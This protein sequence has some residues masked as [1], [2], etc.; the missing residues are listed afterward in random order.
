MLRGGRS[1]A[2]CFALP[3]PPSCS[4][5]SHWRRYA[6][7]NPMPHTARP[8]LIAFVVTTVIAASQAT[9]QDHSM[10]DHPAAISAPSE[11]PLYDD[12]GTYHFAISTKSPD[13]QK[14]FDQG[15]RL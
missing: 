14:Y 5:G 12:L 15:M 10:H 9:A 1:V 13:A 4:T 8:V 7:E 2:T 3:Q 6:E 11:P